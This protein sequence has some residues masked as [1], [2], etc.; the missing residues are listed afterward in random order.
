[1]EQWLS[2]HWVQIGVVWFFVQNFLKALQDA[3]DAEPPEVKAKPIARVSYYMGSIGGY[4]FTGNRIQP[5]QK[6]GV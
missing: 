4:L 6:T 3:E 1:M 5:I 2:Q